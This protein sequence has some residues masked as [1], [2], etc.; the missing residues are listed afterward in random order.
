MQQ[1]G[2]KQTFVVWSL[3]SAGGLGLLHTS[4]QVTISS[5]NQALNT[6]LKADGEE[7][8][9]ESEGVMR[10]TTESIWLCGSLAAADCQCRL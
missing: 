1:R 4:K 2:A 8:Y 5:L 10:M 9:G 6:D 7:G 3:A